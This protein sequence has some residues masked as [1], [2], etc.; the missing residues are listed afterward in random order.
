[1]IKNLS[2]TKN[3]NLQF[4]T[5]AIVAWL[6][7]AS[8]SHAVSTNAVFHIYHQRIVP[9]SYDC[10]VKESTAINVRPLLPTTNITAN[11]LYVF[12][13]DDQ[14]VISVPGGSSAT[15]SSGGPCIGANL[16]DVDIKALMPT[17]KDGAFTITLSDFT[18]TNVD[19]VN[20]I[21]FSGNQVVTYDV[22]APLPPAI[23]ET[24]VDEQ[25]CA[26]RY[27]ECGRPLQTV[28]WY[29]SSGCSDCSRLGSPQ[30]SFGLANF[31]VKVEDTP[32]WHETAVGEPLALNMRFS[33]YKNIFPVETFGYRWS[34]NWNSSVTVL[35]SKTNRMVFPSG[36]ISLFTQSVAN[37]YL[38]P[39]AMEGTL[40][41]TNGVFRY[42][43][44]DGWTWDYAQSALDTNLYLLSVV[45][46]AW[47]NTVSVTYTNNDRLYRVQQTVPD[48][49]RYLEFFY[50]EAYSVA[51]SVVLRSSATNIEK[52]ATF[53]YTNMALLTNVVDMGG[54]SYSYEYNSG[55]LLSR[56]KKGTADRMVVSYSD[57]PMDWTASNSYWVQLTDAGGYTRKYTWLYGLV[58]ED[59]TRGGDQQVNFYNV[60][61]AGSRGRVLTGA[62]ENGNQQQY[63]YN[64]QGRVTNRIDRTGAQWRQ[65]YNAQNRLLTL[66]DPLTNKTTNV[67]AANGVDLLYVQ[68]PSGPAQRV[69]TYVTN[70]HAVAMESNALGR[71]ITNS[72]NFLGLVTNTTDGRVT[73]EFSYN[74]E[75]RLV[76]HW[77]NGELVA[78]NQYD[79]FGR[80]YW[81]RDAAGLETWRD[82]DGLNRLVSETF[83]N[84]GQ[85]STNIIEYDC[86][87]IDWIT[88]RDG[89][90]WDLQ[91]NDIGELVQAVNPVGLTNDYV[92]GIERQPRS[93]SNILHW[94]TRQY[95]PEGWIKSVAYPADRSYDPNYHAENFWYDGEGRMTKQQAV[96]GAYFR[97]GYDSM[98][99]LL[100]AEVP[101]GSNLAFGVEQYVLAETNKYDALGRKWWTQDIR[102]L[103]TS[104]AFNS[105]GQVLKT[106]YPDAST[107]EWTYNQWGQV[108]TYKD[109]AGNAASNTYDGLGRLSRQIDPRQASFY[110]VY[111]NADL[112]SVISNSAGQVWNFAYDAERRVRE[113]IHPDPAVVE[114]FAYSPMGAVTQHMVGDVIQTLAYDGLGDRSSVQVDGLVVE[115]NRYDRLG[116][117]IWRLDADGLVT[118]NAWDSWGER[119]GSYGPGNQGES[120][121]HGDRGLTNVADRLGIPTS[122]LRDSLGRVVGVVDGAAN[123]V[124]Y[125]YWSNGINQI[126]FLWDGNSNRTDWAYDIYGNPTNRV[127]ANGTS[128]RFQYSKLNLLTN[129]FDAANVATRYTYDANGNLITLVPGS[130]PTISFDYDALNQP[131]NMADGSGATRW[132]YDSMGRLQAETGPFGAVVSNSYDNYGRLT[133]ISF[134]GLSWG[135]E[136]DDLG[137]VIS[138]AAPEGAYAFTY[139]A[140]GGRRTSVLY[141]NGVT[142]S[143]SYDSWIRM[144]NLAWSAGGINLLAIDYAYDAGD[145]RT[146][147][148]WGSSR[149]MAYAYDRAYQLT[150]A[151]STNLAADNAGYRYDK[152]GNPLY[153]KES[154]LA[155]TNSF[156]SLNQIVNG[157]W[158]GG[159]VTVAGAVNYNA[160]TVTVNGTVANRVGLF[161]ER[162]NVSLS[163]GTNVITAIYAGPA[164]GG[165]A[166]AT[167]Q[168]SVVVGNTVY[169]HDANGNLTNDASFTYQYDA[170]NRLTNVVVR[171]N[172]APV[173]ACRYDGLGR[174]VEAIRS[175]T[176]TERYVYFPG[177]FLVLA[178]LDGSNNVKSVFTQGPDLSGIL[179]GA[180]GIG[181]ALS[182]I[183]YGGVGNTNFLHADAMGNIVLAT[184]PSRVVTATIYYGP[185]GKPIVQ[186]GAFRPRFLYSSKEWE[187]TVGL[188]YFGY[189]LYSPALGQWLSRDPLGEQA[190]PLHNLYRCVGNNPLN[191][192]DPDGLRIYAVQG[193]YP[194]GSKLKFASGEA[195]YYKADKWYEHLVA[196]PLNMFSLGGNL[197]QAFVADAWKNLDAFGFAGMAVSAEMQLAKQGAPLVRE[198]ISKCAAKGST[199]A[200]DLLLQARKHLGNGKLI[201]EK[202]AN[203][204]DLIIRTAD[205]TKSI[206]FDLSNPHGLD[207]HVNVEAW[208]PRNL[209]PGDRTMLPDPSVVPK[210]NLHL[211]PPKE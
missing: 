164:F 166:A 199:G 85:W 206:R 127:Y 43:Q 201:I 25:V 200:D 81:T 63:Q 100:T 86:C 139:L 52:T 207:P 195:S 40:V 151:V 104:N 74:G 153:R 136:Y 110:L 18:S 135:Y 112:V 142:E 79:A 114:T 82:Y 143:N 176:N 169:G 7:V 154:G 36:S 38:P 165:V 21:E 57:W 191:A 55:Y 105:L 113:I 72:Y 34:C 125:A 13:A 2:G 32:I 3:A 189:R 27:D 58:Q 15:R 204:S 180:G 181:G 29:V 210:G 120:Y 111:T 50:Y 103:V 188:Y 168:T 24:N 115:S 106:W 96:S 69:F 26:M 122:I 124:S 175:G 119:M 59:V 159:A 144:T 92:Y 132:A 84:N 163:V 128:N 123:P 170:L 107:E 179:G 49:G 61:T 160:G 185:F 152:A 48:T 8:S 177:S 67:Y 131:T 62:M 16:A 186:A 130:N 117:P 19:N 187:G 31:N 129:K 20:Q 211:F 76:A 17:S 1:M 23:S 109:R 149:R 73:N 75:G 5:L 87:S 134:A 11:V 22:A 37:V 116:R 42:T 202:P 121:Q 147:E 89:K 12:G 184:D 205:K 35:D 193:S 198:G 178:V 194:W 65:T 91:Y 208:K 197:A 203:G 155:V 174:R 71:V 172:G 209:F 158:T 138:L 145:R 51:T 167:A 126:Q 47:S 60:S 118:T 80:L 4:I 93:V 94:T 70:K 64:A 88:D 46:D 30:V 95:T 108:L 68:P 10:S 161:Y 183:D 66:T 141:P 44:L 41:K 162:T 99:R 9:L 190:D 173:L 146:N 140:Q 182:Q 28:C 33:N 192:V 39:G 101:D 98:G 133:G 150:N 90:T 78:T 102:G 148:V 6:A 97:Y 77:R 83:D 137:R 156:N 14:A 53:S 45:R 157:S 54:N 196:Q 171:T 56:V